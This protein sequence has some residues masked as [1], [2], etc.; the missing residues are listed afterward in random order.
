MAFSHFVGV[1]P[2]SRL[3]AHGSAAV[4]LCRW[5]SPAIAPFAHRAERLFRHRAMSFQS[6]WSAP[7]DEQSMCQRAIHGR[8]ATARAECGPRSARAVSAGR[9]RYTGMTRANDAEV[10]RRSRILR[11]GTPCCCC[12]ELDG[13]AAKVPRGRSSDERSGCAPPPRAGRAPPACVGAL[14]VAQADPPSRC[15]GC[16]SRRGPSLGR[17]SKH[18]PLG[19]ETLRRAFR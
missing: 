7:Q 14:R 6:S 12:G 13:A 4:R 15:A 1:I 11:H 16:P 3:T 8:S 5:D 2:R 17:P 19:V 10:P 18:R 9:S